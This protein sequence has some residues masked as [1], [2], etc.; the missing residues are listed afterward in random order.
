MAIE[1]NP[2]HSPRKVRPA[3]AH[4]PA[5]HANTSLAASGGQDYDPESVDQTPSMGLRT[6][7]PDGPTDQPRP[8]AAPGGAVSD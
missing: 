6:N 3:R 2:T 8:D 4:A 7:R 5:G 1:P